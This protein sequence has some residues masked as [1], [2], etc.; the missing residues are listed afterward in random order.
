MFHFGFS[1]VGFIYLLMLFIPNI[2]W[3]K[4][5]PVN[6]EE[7]SQKESRVLQIIEKTGE[8]L[9]CCCVLIFSDFNIKF[10][11]I[12]CI[13]LLGSFILMVLYE[14]YWI[15]YF[16]SKKEMSDL[17]IDEAKYKAYLK[18]ADDLDISTKAVNESA[19]D[20]LKNAD[21]LRAL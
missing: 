14:I 3:T 13:W 8:I 19:T 16:R 4:H 10:N 2:I 1:Y 12:W 15:R 7:Y 9:V 18:D 11:S 20:I 6:Y 17:N 5:K 21:G